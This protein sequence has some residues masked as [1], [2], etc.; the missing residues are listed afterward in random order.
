MTA[1]ADLSLKKNVVLTDD[2][3]QSAT[4]SAGDQVTFSL[5]VTNEVIETPTGPALGVVVTDKLSSR[6]AYLSDTGG[7]A[8]DPATGKWTI[9]RVDLGQTVTL[10][11]TAKVLSTGEFRNTAEVTESLSQDPDSVPA[12]DDGDQDEDDEATVLVLPV[13]GLAVEIGTPVPKQNGNYTI[14][15]SFVLENIGIVDVCELRLEDDLTETFGEGN[16]CI[17]HITSDDGHAQTKSRLRWG[18]RH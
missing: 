18:D 11:I 12:N 6:Y 16:D 17:S 7:G 14:P 3:D 13:V 5:S 9:G 4:V 15:M 10:D 1:L 8:Y 2:G